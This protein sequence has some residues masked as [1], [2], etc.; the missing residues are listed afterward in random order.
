MRIV[1]DDIITNP[2]VVGKKD[3]SRGEISMH[4]S[5]RLQIGHALGDL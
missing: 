3:V 1:Y 2:L 5:S 4:A